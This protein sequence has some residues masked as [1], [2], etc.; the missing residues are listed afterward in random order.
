VSQPTVFSA[1]GLRKR[2]S[3]LKEARRMIAQHEPSQWRVQASFS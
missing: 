2:F 1:L 3:T